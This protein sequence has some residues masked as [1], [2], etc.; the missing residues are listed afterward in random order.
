MYLL[1][2]PKVRYIKMKY[3]IV[4]FHFNFTIHFNISNIPNNL[5][6]I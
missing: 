2:E 1:T 4:F 5:F 6:E 3:A